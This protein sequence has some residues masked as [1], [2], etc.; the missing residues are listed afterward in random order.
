MVL[1]LFN[2][3][4]AL[5]KLSNNLKSSDYIS[6]IAGM[7]EKI[8]TLRVSSDAQ[9]YFAEQF[10]ALFHVDCCAIYRVSEKPAI[11]I[12]SLDCKPSK[13]NNKPKFNNRLA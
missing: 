13:R 5:V 4:L 6:L 12:R 1:S 2:F 7:S 9:Q 10:K 3:N 8:P 11:F